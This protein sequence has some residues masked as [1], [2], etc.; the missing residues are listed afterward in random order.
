MLETRVL[1][2]PSA[3]PQTALWP[4]AQPRSIAD[5]ENKT[6]LGFALWQSE[7][8][9]WWTWW[10]WPVLSV[11]EQEEAPLVFTVRRAG[12]WGL[13][14]EVRDAEGQRIGTFDRNAIYDRNHLLYARARSNGEGVSYENLAGEALASMRPT[15]EGMELTF[16]KLIETDPFAKMLVLAAALFQN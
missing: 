7:A 4:A 9:R 16:T 14:H 10:H 11:Y 3:E 2:F 12:L 8:S 13:Q 15:P 6:T 1:L 5:A